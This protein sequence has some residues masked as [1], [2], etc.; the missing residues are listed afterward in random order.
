MTAEELAE[1]FRADRA[2][3]VEAE[4]LIDRAF[5]QHDGAD[6]GEVPPSRGRASAVRRAHSHARTAVVDRRAHHRRRDP[7]GQ[8]PGPASRRTSIETLA[9]RGLALDYAH[10]VGDDRERLT[11]LLRDSFAR[12]DSC[13]SFGGIGATPDDHTRQAAAAALG[14]PLVRHPEAVAR[15]R[16]A[17][18]RR[19]VSASRADG[20]VSGRRRRSFRIRSTASPRSR[21]ATITS[22]PA[23]R[24]WRG[25]CSTGCSRRCVS[26]LARAR[27]RSSARSRVR[28]GR[29]PAPAADER[30]R[31]AVPALKLFSLP[32]F[33]ADGGRRIELGV[34]GDPAR[35]GRGD[36]ASARRR[37]R[38]AGFRFAEMPDDRADRGLKPA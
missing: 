8:A 9:A 33:L 22:S 28:R 31:R 24:R 20:G 29:K 12:G 14:V 19:G 26:D 3:L 30:E 25:R 27:R 15:A 35:R 21:S 2:R 34:R 7:V 37:A 36:R 23:F 5:T 38:R 4:P 6:R 17:V 10:Y 18:R 1:R 11:A 16:G 13:S 32:S